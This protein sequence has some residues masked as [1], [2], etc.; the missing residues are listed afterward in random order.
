M[1]QQAICGRRWEERYPTKSVYAAAIR[2]AAQ[3]LVAQRLML[4]ADADRVIAEA[5][6]NGV[7]TGP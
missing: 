2:A 6:K 3:N 5:E 4:A 1:R 7:R